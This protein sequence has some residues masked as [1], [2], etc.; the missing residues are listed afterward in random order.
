MQRYTHGRQR[1]QTSLFCQLAIFS[2]N[3]PS[4][5]LKPLS[6]ET[7]LQLAAAK[8][9]KQAFSDAMLLVFTEKRTTTCFLCLGEESWPLEKRTYEFASTGDLTEHFKRKHLAHIKEGDQLQC[10]VCRMG[11]Q[12]KQHLQNQAESIHGTVL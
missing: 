5:V 12:H 7:S 4:E 9:E 1:I 3:R 10:K 8:A 6:K 11:L 2:A